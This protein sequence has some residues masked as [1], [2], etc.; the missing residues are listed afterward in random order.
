MRLPSF[1]KRGGRESDWLPVDEAEELTLDE[2]VPD[3]E[4]LTDCRVRAEVIVAGVVIKT[5]SVIRDGKRQ[6]EAELDDESGKI[7]RLVW[8]GRRSIPGLI[9]G[10][11]VRIRG[12]LQS[13]ADRFTMIDPSYTILNRR[14]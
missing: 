8:L 1:F 13:R 5:D 3:R 12:T 11:T 10:A 7:L 2:L 6:F 14:A 4:L 9:P